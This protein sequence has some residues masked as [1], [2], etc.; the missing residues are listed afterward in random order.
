MLVASREL[1]NLLLTLVCNT[2]SHLTGLF[3]T[4]ESGGLVT[5]FNDLQEA[6][7]YRLLLRLF[8]YLGDLSLAGP[9]RVHALVVEA[10]RVFFNT[11]SL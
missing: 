10:D 2:I 8:V 7:A 11:V 3:L 1:V 5:I 9:C 6:A 4:T